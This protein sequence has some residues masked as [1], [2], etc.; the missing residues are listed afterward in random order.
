MLSQSVGLFFISLVQCVLCTI[1][2]EVVGA[3]KFFLPPYSFLSC[4]V[5]SRSNQSQPSS[6]EEERNSKVKV[7]LAG[8]KKPKSSDKLLLCYSQKMEFIDF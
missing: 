4:V 5:F 2:N 7:F 8:G 6:K 1:L 3:L